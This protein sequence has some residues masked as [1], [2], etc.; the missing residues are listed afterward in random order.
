MQA[1]SSTAEGDLRHVSCDLCGSNRSV[2]I[3]RKTGTLDDRTFTIVRCLD[4]DLVYVN[5][6]LDDA[7]LEALYGAEYYRGRGFDRTV[8][9][10]R[11]AVRPFEDIAR[12][13]SFAVETLADALGGL[14]ARRILDVGCGTGGLVRSLNARGADAVGSDSSQAAMLACA[15]NGTPLSPHS[16]DELLA[17]GTTFDAVTACE[18]IEHTVSPRGFLETMVRLVKPGGVLYLTTG[19]WNLVSRVSGTPYVMPEGHIYYFTPVTMR[20][21]FTLAGLSESPVL[22]RSWAG[23]RVLAPRIGLG[24]TTALARTTLRVAPGYAPFPIGVRPLR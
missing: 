4:C 20:K 22:N 7:A 3:A 24:A 21:Y 18:V 9:Y 23:Y 19:N 11:E 12:A 10:E 5:P 15:L 1:S 13:W 17:A 8:C 6:R 14:R 2:E 16:I